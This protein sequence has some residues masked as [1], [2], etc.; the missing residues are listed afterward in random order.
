MRGTGPK[1]LLIPL[2]AATLS[3]VWLIAG[4]FLPE[5]LAGYYTTLR[6]AFIYTNFF[7]MLACG[8][9]AF[10]KSAGRSLP[11][12]IACLMLAII[13]FFVLALNATV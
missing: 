3:F 11:T 8:L 10:V 9:V 1:R 6:F 2:Y 4:A 12:G 13:W 7:T 5:T